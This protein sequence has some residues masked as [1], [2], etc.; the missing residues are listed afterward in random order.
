MRS[1]LIILFSVVLFF[2]CTHHSIWSYDKTTD[3]KHWAQLSNAYLNCSSGKR[4]S[5]INLSSK[6]ST[7]SK[8]NFQLKYHPSNVDIINN[9][10]TVEFDLE[11]KNYLILHNIK[12]E[13]VQFHWHSQSEHT[14]EGRHFPL[15]LHLVHK[16]KNNIA[17]LGVLVDII[18]EDR[19]P[20]FFDNIPAIGKHQ[21][22]RV[23]LSQLI[24]Q[25]KSHYYYQGSLT[26][27]PCTEGV[28][29]IVFDQHIKVSRKQLQKFT[30]FYDHNFRK[31]Q[32]SY[33]RNIFYN[34]HKKL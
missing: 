16:N 6:K 21:K 34:P 28:Q 11:E 8:H 26:T 4:Q 30:F 19:K 7:H 10:H 20:H 23:D 33:S 14:V 22:T 31:T 25:S 29:W 1:A 24:P 12:F 27:P 9:G 32:P 18:E 15:E 2:Q 13:L 3:E 17:V 5:P